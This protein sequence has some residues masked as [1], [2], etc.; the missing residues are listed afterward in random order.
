MWTRRSVLRLAGSAT[1]AAFAARSYGIDYVAAAT[2][3]VENRSPEDVAALMSLVERHPAT[4]LALDL[5]AGTL[6]A[7]TMRCAIALPPKVREAF[8]TGAWDTTGMLLHDYE[9]VRAT[10]QRLP[11]VAGL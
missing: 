6:D 10:A 5:Q 2:A 9:Q 4:V 8:A 7:G 11:Y 3:A 1:G